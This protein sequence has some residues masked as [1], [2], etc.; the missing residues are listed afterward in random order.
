MALICGRGLS[1]TPPIQDG[2]LIY[3]NYVE[4][5]AWGDPHNGRR[6]GGLGWLSEANGA[7]VRDTRSKIAASPINSKIFLL[8]L[9]TKYDCK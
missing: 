8:P 5:K 7:K 1:I 6:F 9:K 2:R 3:A 4:L